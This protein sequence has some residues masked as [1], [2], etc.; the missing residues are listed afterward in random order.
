MERLSS[1]ETLQ[2]LEF[3]EVQE[4]EGNL[5][6]NK[7]KYRDVIAVITNK[8]KWWNLFRPL[9]VVTFIHASGY[10]SFAPCRKY[11]TRFKKFF[12]V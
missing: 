3:F 12:N 2:I 8:D 5:A 7:D 6:I 9:Y 11:Q 1:K 4:R 10:N